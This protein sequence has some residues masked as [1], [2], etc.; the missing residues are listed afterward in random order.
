MGLREDI[1]SGTA[2]PM[3]VNDMRRAFGL[4][5]Y[6]SKWMPDTMIVMGNRGGKTL[7]QEGWEYAQKMADRQ[8]REEA[9]PTNEYRTYTVSNSSTLTNDLTYFPVYGYDTVFMGPQ[10]TYH[11]G[12]PLLQKETVAKEETPE[13]WLRRRVEEI[14]WRPA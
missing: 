9:M 14:C 12:D 11:I 13:A 1:L 4:P 6:T 7:A 10:K 8:K 5:V 2:A 3:S